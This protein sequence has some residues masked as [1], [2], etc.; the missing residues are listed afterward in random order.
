MDK[1]DQKLMEAA[2]EA[3]LILVPALAEEIEL[4]LPRGATA[5]ELDNF[6]RTKAWLELC[7]VARRAGLEPIEY[8]KQI[9]S[10]R[11]QVLGRIE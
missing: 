11:R 2:V 6:R 8:A 3:F 1:N 10:V 7:Q 4:N 9:V 5:A